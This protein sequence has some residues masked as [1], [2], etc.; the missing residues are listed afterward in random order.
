M[1]RIALAQTAVVADYEANVEKAF[2]LMAQAAAEKAQI[3][4]FPECSFR[5][6][7]GQHRAQRKYWALAETV[8]GPTVDRFAEKAR[9][10]KLT[11]IINLAEKA[12]RGE[13]YNCSAVIDPD[14]SLLGKTH[15]MHIPEAPLNNE[16]YYF[17]PGK[18]G[19]TVYDTPSA[20]VGVAICY[21]RHFPETFRALTLAGAEI[22]FIQAAAGGENMQ[23]VW[24]IELQAAAIA[25]MVF[26]AA[27]NHAGPDNDRPYF[28]LSSAV[29]PRGEIFAQA[30]DETDKLLIVD[31][32]LD[33]IDTARQ[34]YPFFRDRRPETYGTLCR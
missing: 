11:T 2:S 24:Q 8:P 5:Q 27:V 33:Q 23:S 21:D 30:A 14:G 32:D 6:W 12:G 17:W 1:T 26:I 16:K 9:R 15:K 7:F 31:C 19:Y 3:I 10:H 22:I 34:I 29:N 4:C 13:Y 28:G 20:K 25:N 18:T